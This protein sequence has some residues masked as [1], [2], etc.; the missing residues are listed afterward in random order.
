MKT[1]RY[2]SLA[3]RP[4]G[5]LQINTLEH[6]ASRNRA[7]P[8]YCLYNYSGEVYESRHWA[9]L[10]KTISGGGTGMLCDP[11]VPGSGSYPSAWNEDL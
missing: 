1:S 3:H 10:S 4:N 5:V 11:T 6:Y 9:L 8:L 2:L 7:T